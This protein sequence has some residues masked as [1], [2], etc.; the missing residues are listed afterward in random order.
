M[1]ILEVTNDSR[2]IIKKLHHLYASYALGQTSY[3][4]LVDHLS[5]YKNSVDVDVNREIILIE[6][7][8]YSELIELLRK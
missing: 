7:K 8:L 4:M 1:R 3:E 2:K 5:N 6:E